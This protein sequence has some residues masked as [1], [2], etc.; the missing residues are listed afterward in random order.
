MTECVDKHSFKRYVAQVVGERYVVPLLGVWTRAA[1]ID[2]D[3]L[4]ESFAIKS[5]WGSGSRHVLLVRD[6]SKLDPDAAKMRFSSWVQPWE[7]VY[8]HT[9]DWAYKDIKPKIIAEKLIVNKE[10]EYK[11]FCFNGEPKFFYVA[12]DSSPGGRNFHNYYDMDWNLL[13]FTRHSRNASFDIARPDNFDEM[14]DLARKLSAPFPHVRVDLCNT[15]DGLLVEELTFYV[16]SGTGKFSP[17][18]WDVKFGAPF[19]LPEPNSEHAVASNEHIARKAPVS[20][21]R[22]R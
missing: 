8:Y 20:M 18:D 7:N 17:R 19:V 16:G 22:K 13:P 1:D 3:V 2:F 4:P 15:R 9:F 21:S 12:T 5:N 10:Y 6:K 11:F 14:L